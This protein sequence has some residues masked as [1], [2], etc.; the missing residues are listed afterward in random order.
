MTD[1]PAALGDSDPDAGQTRS[2]SGVTGP[3]GGAAGSEAS[4]SGRL[5]SLARRTWERGAGAPG[6]SAP[7]QSAPGQS[8]P[9]QSA[10]GEARPGQLPVRAT[11]VA[12]VDDQV[13]RLLRQT[14]AWA[15]RLIL[16]AI[17]IDGAFRVAVTLRLV[18]LPLIAALLLT[19]LLQPLS[20]RLRRVGLPGLLATWCTL[21]IAIVVIA[22]AV[23]LAANRVSADYPRLAAEVQ[24]TATELQRSLAGPPFHL[25]GAR[26]Q[27]LTKQ[28]TQFLSQH[29][30]VI[31]GT[32]VTG[33]RIFLES[34][35]GLVLTLF[36][37]FFLLKDGARIWS[38]VISGLPPEANR[39]MSQAGTAAW[40][41]L[42]GY[43]RGTTAV[44]AIHAVFIGLALWILGVPLLVPLIVLVFLAAFIPLIGILVVGALAI[45]VTLA[46]KGWFAA[47]ILVAV[48]LVENQIESHLLQPLVVGRA[49]RLH[50]L[51]IILALAV[52]GVIAGIP[53]AIV[54]VPAAAVITYAWPQLRGSAPVSPPDD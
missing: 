6:Q 1:R 16:V 53:G 11:A 51:A 24:R 37:S 44:A 23:T 29:K 50:P 31:A 40:H 25:K 35:T 18:V 47:V 52:G 13:P 20:A 33:G 15:W 54:A 22:G 46:T 5:R 45:L 12:S 30:A 3:G 7:G 4:V 42:T 17:L 41:A 34:L 43:I 36:I 49:V 28:L 8:A 48:F 10:P 9:G 21:L 27:Q 19:A 39:R 2:E 26:L 14:A 32:V 38:W